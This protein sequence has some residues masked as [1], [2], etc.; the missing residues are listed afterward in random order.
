[1]VKRTCAADKCDN[2]YKARGLCLKHYHRAA[3]AGEFTPGVTDPA[4]RFWSKVDKSGNC[5]EWT[6]AIDRGGYGN[7][8]AGPNDRSALAHRYALKVSGID[9]PSGMHVDHTC[10]NRACVNP[11]HLRFVTKKQNGENRAGPRSDNTS[12][13]LDV[14]L[15]KQT[16]RWTVAVVHNGVRHS[17]GTYATAE[18][19]NGAAI[20]LRN[21]LY[22]HNIRD[23][24]A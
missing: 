4:E 17:G 12:G 9:I 13:Y 23:H 16:S 1:M 21:K 6:A 3:K 11:D 5:W 20:S 19:A 15:N 24:S 18:A 7:F 8:Y 2:P 22:T 14:Y 10:W